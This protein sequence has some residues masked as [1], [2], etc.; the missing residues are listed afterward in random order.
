MKKKQNPKANEYVPLD[1]VIHTLRVS[2]DQMKEWLHLGVVTPYRSQQGL[3]MK[4]SDFKAV[5]HSPIALNAALHALKY[6]ARRRKRD[7]ESGQADAFR[8]ETEAMISVL[9]DQAATLEAI[10]KKYHERFDVLRDQS[11]V[12]AAYIIFS[13][14]FRLFRMSFLCV[15]NQYWDSLILVRPINEALDLATYFVIEKDSQQGKQHIRKWFCENK[16][17]SHSICRAAIENYATKLLPQDHDAVFQGLMNRLYQA[18]SKTIHIGH[19]DIMEIYVPEI[20]NGLLKGVGFDYGPCSY[21]RKIH[22][23]ARYMR[24]VLLAAVNSFTICFQVA[25][26]LVAAADAETLQTLQK[27]LLLQSGSGEEDE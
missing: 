8:T 19:H 7:E 22:G 2:S 26:P 9:K 5:A 20:D 14:V 1:E 18:T 25:Y 16:S 21:P 23:T 11:G 10:H 13:K 27:E 15:E 4:K 6:E 17:P 3:V 24:S 12:V